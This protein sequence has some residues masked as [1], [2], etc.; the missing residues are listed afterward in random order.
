MNPL[1][2]MDELSARLTKNAA[3]QIAYSYE[4]GTNIVTVAISE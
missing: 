2:S 3:K 1:L 4:A